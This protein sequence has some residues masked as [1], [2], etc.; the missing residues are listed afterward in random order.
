MAPPAREPGLW[1]EIHNPQISSLSGGCDDGVIIIVDVI[2]IV[3]VVIVVVVVI[4]IVVVIITYTHIRTWEAREHQTACAARAQR[5]QR[6]PLVR[7]SST[8]TNTSRQSPH[9]SRGA[10]AGH[11]LPHAQDPSQLELPIHR[12]P[13]HE[14]TH[15]Y[16]RIKQRTASCPALVI[17]GM[18]NS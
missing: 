3:I 6:W 14:H 7:C 13:P 16:E 2:V 10:A 8:C 11:F 12:V 18:S 4:D 17:V 9:P 1:N 15:I 5:H